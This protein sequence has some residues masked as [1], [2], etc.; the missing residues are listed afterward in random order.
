MRYFSVLLTDLRIYM[1]KN[2]Q[3]LH[4]LQTLL[5]FL[6]VIHTLLCVIRS[7]SPYPI[8]SHPHPLHKSIFLQC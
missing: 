5:V 8:P 7:A 3:D 6:W 2:K 1:H 4:F